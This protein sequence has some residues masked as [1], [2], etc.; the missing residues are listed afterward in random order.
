MSWSL[1]TFDSP[2]LNQ[3][4][5]NSGS[6]LTFLVYYKG[7]NSRSAKWKRCL[8]LGT[9]ERVQTFQTL[10][11]YIPL[12]A[13]RV[14]THLEALQTL[15]FRAFMEISLQKRG[16]LN[17]SLATDDWTQSPALPSPQR[18]ESRAESSK[19]LIPRSVPQAA[20]HPA[21]SSL[22]IFQ[23]SSN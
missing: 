2:A 1:C 23:K 15:M 21:S 6:L 7:Y 12:L 11:R 20:S 13:P 10:S 3:D 14:F 19:P 8:G 16:W 17:K 9:W 4:S 18:S 22:R 5:Q